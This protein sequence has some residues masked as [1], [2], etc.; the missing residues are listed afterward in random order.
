LLTSPFLFVMPGYIR[1]KTRT[2]VTYVSVCKKEFGRNSDLVKHS[3]IFIGKR[4]YPVL[5]IKVKTECKEEI[6]NGT[7]VTAQSGRSPVIRQYVDMST[8][9]HE[10][11][12][13]VDKVKDTVRMNRILSFNYNLDI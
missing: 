2:H 10:C 11:I 13:V 7:D 8:V 4:P 5:M 3:R 9:K 6:N 1:V 12:D